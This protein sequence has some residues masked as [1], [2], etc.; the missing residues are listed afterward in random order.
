MSYFKKIYPL[1][2]EIRK[3]LLP[4]WGRAAIIKQKDGSAVNVV[5][6]LDIQIETVAERWL[7][8]RYP[9]VPFVGEE[10]GGNRRADRFWLMDPIDGTQ[11][12]VRGLPFCTSMLALIENGQVVFSAI[13]DF[14]H[15]DIYWAEQG[16]GAFC[17]TK[18][19]K[20]SHRSLK[21]AYIGW[22]IKLNNK[23]NQIIFDKLRRQAV[24]I[25][26]I[27]AG[28]EF[29]MIACGKLDARVCFDPHGKDYDY[30]PGALLVSEAGGVVANVGR[31]SYDYRNTDFIAANPV[32][33]KELTGGKKAIFPVLK[34]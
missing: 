34:R 11:H 1:F 12:F 3:H 23:A 20:V 17:G 33:Y 21:E 25:K 13:Y 19:L 22:E 2:K 14:I 10:H 16:Q 27:S 18:R 29:A 24:L 31:K 26:T 7:A 9:G 8:K 15:N 6:A 32:I 28:W 5:T 30:A 4:H